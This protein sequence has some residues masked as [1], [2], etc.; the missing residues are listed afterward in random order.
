[1]YGGIRRRRDGHGVCCGEYQLV[2]IK[3]GNYL[4]LSTLFLQRR[5][6]H[7]AR[8]CRIVDSCALIRVVS[9]ITSA[10]VNRY[11]RCD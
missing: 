5:M 10:E 7:N 9:F 8:F 3:I 6:D 4:A 2:M 1:M 11:D